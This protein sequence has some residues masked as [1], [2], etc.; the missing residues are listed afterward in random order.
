LRQQ[1]QKQEEGQGG[2][3]AR[4][5]AAADGGVEASCEDMQGRHYFELLFVFR[6]LCKRPLNLSHVVITLG[7]AISARSFRDGL[8][9]TLPSTTTKH[10]YLS[11]DMQSAAQR[12]E[13][14]RV[15][16]WPYPAPSCNEF[17]LTILC[18]LLPSCFFGI[19]VTKEL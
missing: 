2:S 13:Q 19:Y 3:D 11:P 18:A 14:L 4:H 9:V 5:G 6:M 12:G 8:G 17:H 10:A 1:G 16:V 7:P 15:F